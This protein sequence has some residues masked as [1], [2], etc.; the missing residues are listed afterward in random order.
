ML[1][2]TEAE[3]AARSQYKETERRQLEE[4]LRMEQQRIQDLLAIEQRGRDLH[5]EEEQDS[6]SR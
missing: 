1:R 2:M 4:A 5:D 6:N 3:A